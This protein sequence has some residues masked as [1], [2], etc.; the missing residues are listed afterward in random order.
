[1]FVIVIGAWIAVGAI[2]WGTRPQNQNTQILK[3]MKYEAHKKD[4]DVYEDSDYAEILNLLDKKDNAEVKRRFNRITDPEKRKKIKKLLSEQYDN[5]KGKGK[6]SLADVE[7]DV[8]QANAEI[9]SKHAFKLFCGIFMEIIMVAVV[10]TAIYYFFL[11]KDNEVEK[12][13]GIDK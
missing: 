2:I 5:G 4:D 8:E 9:T 7:F 13:F 1:M 6:R 12:F 10:V 3:D 11:A